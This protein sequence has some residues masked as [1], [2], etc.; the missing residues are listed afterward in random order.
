MNSSNQVSQYC[1]FADGFGL[2]ATVSG[3]GRPKTGFS[4]PGRMPLFSIGLILSWR[5]EKQ[6]HR[7]FVGSPSRCEGLHFLRMTSGG[8]GPVIGASRTSRIHRSFAF[9]QDDIGLRM[10][11]TSYPCHPE[12]SEGS[13]HWGADMGWT[14]H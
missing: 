9:A 14:H 13:M 3:C 11:S 1:S 4:R 7:S 2:F 6:I 5:P 12:R 10:T 8:V